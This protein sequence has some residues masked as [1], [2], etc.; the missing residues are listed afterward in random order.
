MS[1][2]RLLDRRGFWPPTRRRPMHPGH[3][4]AAAREAY[5]SSHYTRAPTRMAQAPAGGAYGW[6]GRGTERP[7]AAAEK[8]SARARSR[9]LRT[10]RCS[11]RPQSMRAGRDGQ[12]LRALP[13]AS[14][15]DRLQIVGRNAYECA[16]ASATGTFRGR[17]RPTRRGY[18]N[19][20]GAEVHP[21]LKGRNGTAQGPGR[22][23]QDSELVALLR[24]GCG[25]GGGCSGASPRTFPRRRR[26]SRR[27][28]LSAAARA[29]PRC[30]ACP[31]GGG[32]DGLAAPECRVRALVSGRQST[33]PLPTCV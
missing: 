22:Q 13:G 26:V 20:G 19:K 12:L 27:V 5:A 1:T 28:G 4:L 9:G 15:Q 6:C 3:A 18:C 29:A 16:N 33:S 8:E 7:G 11:A 30:P 23:C 21:G 32:D 17:P 25:E 14:Y 31:V 24:R 2:P 10:C